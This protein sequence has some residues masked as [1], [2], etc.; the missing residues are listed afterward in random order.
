[1]AVRYFTELKKTLNLSLALAKSDFKSK[2]EGSYLGILWY[3][4]NPGL[5]FVLLWGIFSGQFGES[6]PFYP[7]YLLLGVIIFNF[8]QQATGDSVGIILANGNLI[9]SIKFPYQALVLGVVWRTFFSHLFEIALLVGVLFYLG[10]GL[11]GFLWY[12]FF[13]FFYF[14]FIYGVSL[15]IAVTNVYVIDFANIWRFFSLLLWLSTPI[16]YKAD[17]YGQL[18][19]LINFF[20]PLD[21]FLKVIREVLIYFQ[22]PDF[23]MVL[24]I[25]A[26]S[27]G[28]FLV[29]NFVFTKL[30][31]KIAERI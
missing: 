4:L 9:K 7:A 8:F 18:G 3:L 1:M 13:L 6:I 15:L 2:N 17:N 14:L 26:T 10:I 19:K 28:F 30:K 5:M 11:A 24:I 25:V 21:Y 12:P 29:G 16:F 22:V 23:S 31:Y 27:F 20:N